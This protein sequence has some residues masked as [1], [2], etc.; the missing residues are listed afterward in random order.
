[1]PWCSVLGFGR[2]FGDRD[3]AGVSIAALVS[4]AVRFAQRATGSQAPRQLTFQRASALSVELLVDRFVRHT[5]L[6]IISK[7]NY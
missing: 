6:P 5:H 3:S 1:M 2:P 4:L 7:L